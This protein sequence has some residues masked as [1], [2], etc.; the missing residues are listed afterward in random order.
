VSKRNVKN[1]IKQPLKSTRD[2]ST[3]LPVRV[4]E[5]RKDGKYILELLESWGL[6]VSL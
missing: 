1:K 4:R 2:F 6:P 3:P 5:K